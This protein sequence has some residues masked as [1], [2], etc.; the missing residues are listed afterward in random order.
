[1]IK[2]PVS[3]PGD[4]SVAAT[5]RYRG[6]ISYSQKD[7]SEAR[8]LHR[9]LESYRLPSGMSASVDGS[10]RLGRFFHDD[11]EMPAAADIAATVRGA[12]EDSESLI[13]LCSP[14][15]AQS[16]WVNAEI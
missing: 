7:K 6:F 12:I 15:A 4:G 14:R 3:A 9:W 10:R 8:R 2:M 5:W 11:E 13:V 16:R 1:M